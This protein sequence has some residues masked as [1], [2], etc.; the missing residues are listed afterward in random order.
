M[1]IN[2]DKQTKFCSF[3]PCVTFG[4]CSSMVE[5]F[6]QV[7]QFGVLVAGKAREDRCAHVLLWN[8]TLSR[9]TTNPLRVFPSLLTCFYF[10]FLTNKIGQSSKCM[11]WVGLR[12]VLNIFLPPPFLGDRCADV[13][14]HPAFPLSWFPGP[15]FQG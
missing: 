11:W 3:F 14:L 13:L 5:L 15:T 2:R 8:Q 1:N 10:I 12:K 4:R 6:L 7:S 9:L